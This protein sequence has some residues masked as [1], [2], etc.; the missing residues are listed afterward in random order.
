MTIIF[1]DRY[2]NLKGAG[3]RHNISICIFKRNVEGGIG[4]K[5]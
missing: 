2:P 4:W 1:E 5:M 3:R